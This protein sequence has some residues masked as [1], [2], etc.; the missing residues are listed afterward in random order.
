LNLATLLQG[1]ATPE[2]DVALSDI[3][4]DSRAVRPGSVFLACR[5]ERHHGLDFAQAAVGQGAAAILWEP[6]EGRSLPELPSQ[7]IVTPV[8]Q[9]TA[10]ASELAGR[11]FGLPS[12]QLTVVGITGTN[13]K[14]TSAWL[15]AQALTACGR[16]SAYLGTLGAA[17]EGRL[18][19]GEFTTPDA[20]SLQRR[21]AGFRAQGAACVALEVSSHALTQSRAAAVRFDAAVFTNL[22]RD[23]LDYHGSLE[24]YAAAKA[25]L[26]DA[27]GL[28]L[29]VLNADDAIGAALLA[30][31]GFGQAIATSRRADFLPRV[32]Q[33][34]LQAVDIESATTGLR[35]ALRSSFGDAQVASSLIGAFNVD[36]LLAVLGVLLGSGVPLADAVVA[37]RA[38]TA[39][40]GRMAVQGGGR[41]PLVV[42]DYAHTPDALEKALR[43][44]RAH[45]T[46]RL[47]CVFGCGGDRDIGKRAQMGRIAATLADAVIVTD[48][49]P[50]SEDPAAIVRDILKGLAGHQAVVLHDRTAAIAQAII[51]AAPGDAVLVAGKGHEAFQIVGTER[52]P[53]S[54]GHC[55]QQALAQR[56][57]A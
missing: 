26:F 36:N 53:F 8:P 34:W 25:S 30:R 37:L 23:H 27:E 29:R 48:D 22:T 55:V 56:S 43:A 7:I 5:G 38:V 40:P 20:V 16:P 10:L 11:F 12:Q 45:C 46:G 28:R 19:A 35:F 15:L 17:F 2:R 31:E 9:L 51:R 13:G 33:P 24:A 3:T 14:T 4:L 1:I 42:V 32:G 50:R 44:L 49:N 39:P 54:D 47:W 21:L 41:L 57:L 6:E 52:R 18:E